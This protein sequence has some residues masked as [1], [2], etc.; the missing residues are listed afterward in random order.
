MGKR[1]G[2]AACVAF[3]VALLA[4]LPAAAQT[5]MTGEVLN[6]T[7]NLLPGIGD[8]TMDCQPAGTSTITYELVGDAL[9]PYPGTFVE[10][11]SLTIAGGLVQTFE[12]DFTIQSGA[13]EIEGTKTLRTSGS[14]EC[15]VAPESGIL[16]FSSA[17]LE[18]D[19][20]ATIASPSGTFED[21]GR[22]VT[23]ISFIQGLGGSGSGSAQES[24][25]SEAP[26]STSGHVSG[27]GLIH[28][29]AKGLVVFGFVAKSDGTS[30]S[31]K[32]NV[33]AFGTH[34]KCLNATVFVQTPTHATFL[35]D[36]RV[37]GVMTT[38]R[39]DVDDL[40]EPGRNRDTFTIET[41]TGFT[42]TGVL[43]AG[44]I[45]IHQ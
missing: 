1:A 43:E 20:D 26:A 8:F 38:Y 24:F 21:S 3:V 5:V 16:A 17:F 35:G 7:A 33:L 30:T 11:G 28:D 25:I 34:V 37:N 14:A 12:A 13:T 36:A 39:I 27:G 9:G 15:L 18:A 32:C 40:G 10:T 22:A 6:G 44:N 45:Q 2:L 29:A 4:P 23:S 19:Y 31:A 41:G 42:A